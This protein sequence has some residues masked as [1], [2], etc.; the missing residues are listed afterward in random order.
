MFKTFSAL[1]LAATLASVPSSALARNIVLANDDGLTSNVLAL[2]HSLKQAGHDV[3]VAVP[4]H[5]QSGQ[6]AALTI[7]QPLAPLTQACLN[8]AA[9]VGDPGAGPMTREGLPEGDFFYV[10]GTPVM[11]LLYGLDVAGKARWNAA[12]DL[13]L[14]G[15]NEGQN[16]GAI[17]ISSGTVSNAQIATLRGLPAI[18]LSAGA[19]SKG[20]NLDNPLSSQIAALSVELIA[21]LE[22]KAGE[23]RLLP[24]GVALNV[25]FPDEIDGAQW[26]ITKIGTYNAY[27]VGF[28]QN[29]AE[30]STPVMRAMAEA[31]GIELPPLPSVTFGFNTAAPTTEQE[32]DESIV[33]RR[34]IAVSPMQAGYAF[35]AAGEDFFNWQLSDLIAS[36]GTAAN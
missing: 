11:A 36:A 3:I 1:A 20:D 15:P 34:H 26:R 21:A 14:S 31:R 12:P 6:G 24:Q 35:G 27:Q 4:C 9:Q 23:G 29:M 32:N 5:D 17:V 10:E 2:Y 7:G 19:N 18:A 16:V 25:N 28:T 33:Y 30:E 13:V 8:D 22:S